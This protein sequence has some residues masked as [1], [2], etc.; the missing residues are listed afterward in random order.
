MTKRPK[1]MMHGRDHEHG[2]ADPTLIHW[3]DVGTDGTG[4]G[5]ARLPTVKAYLAPITASDH[6]FT[7]GSDYDWAYL[8]ELPHPQLYVDTDTNLISGTGGVYLVACT[9][10]I[11]GLTYDDG[12]D[13]VA[14]MQPAPSDDPYGIEGFVRQQAVWGETWM[15]CS[16]IAAGS[17]SNQLHVAYDVPTLSTPVIDACFGVTLLNPGPVET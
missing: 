9:V 12:T 13:N 2:G 15:H 8:Y 14:W 11:T 10:R 4:G 5:A 6:S 16:Y 1:P 17:P 3:E 7:I